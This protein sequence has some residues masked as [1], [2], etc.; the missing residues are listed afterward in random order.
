MGRTTFW[1]PLVA[2][3]DK[4]ISRDVAVADIARR[5]RQW[6]DVFEQARSTASGSE[7]PLPALRAAVQPDR[8]QE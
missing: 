7:I 3:R 8:S 4:K 5:Y 6:V 1:E 2:L